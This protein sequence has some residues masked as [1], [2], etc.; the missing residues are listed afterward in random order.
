[1]PSPGPGRAYLRSGPAH[2]PLRT[3]AKSRRSSSG[4]L[5]PRSTH[6]SGTRS[7]APQPP[8]HEPC[9][10]DGTRNCTGESPPRR[11]APAPVSRTPGPPGPSRSRSPT[12]ATC[13]QPWESS[14]HAPKA[15][16]SSG[17][18]TRSAARRETP[19]LPARPQPSRRFAQQQRLRRRRVGIHQ[20]LSQHSN[21]LTAD[22][23]A[24]FAM[25][26]PLACSDYYGA[27][28]PPHGHQSTTDL[29]M[30]GP[31]AR[32]EGR[33]RTVP[34]FTITR[35]TREMP[36]STPTASPRLRPMTLT[37]VLLHDA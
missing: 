4:C 12:D 33:P 9:A 7:N 23:L 27:S 1:M 20:R 29:P 10:S 22:L 3:N 24:P 21:L 18:S 37:L 14:A 17:P 15:D 25:D 32:P 5:P 26:T 8:R 16:G 36:S 11:S 35:S 19:R 13:R 30:T 2:G 31:D 34:T 28:A 6:T